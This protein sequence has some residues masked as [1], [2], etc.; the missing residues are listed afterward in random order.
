MIGKIL[1]SIRAKFRRDEESKRKYAAFLKNNQQKDAIASLKK[2]FHENDVA[3]VRCHMISL[4]YGIAAPRRFVKNPNLLIEKYMFT[5][6]ELTDITGC[7]DPEAAKQKINDVVAG[8]IEDKTYEKFCLAREL[9][10]AM[11]TQ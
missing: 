6:E 2:A 11:L 3:K 5:D 9:P 7:D 1:K 10:I 8:L 4:M